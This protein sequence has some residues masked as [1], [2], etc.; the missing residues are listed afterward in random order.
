MGMLDI[1]RKGMQI[2]HGVTASLQTTLYILRGV[3]NQDDGTG[4]YEMNPGRR[5]IIT[6]ALEYKQKL[7]LTDAG[8]EQTSTVS[9]TIPDM[10]TLLAVT[11]NQGL[12]ITDRLILPGNQVKRILA[13]GGFIDPGTG[14]PVATEAYL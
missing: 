14:V 6:G 9:V 4:D 1:V 7:V 2:T 8:E 12:L 10:V 13:V 11:N 5:Q 3:D